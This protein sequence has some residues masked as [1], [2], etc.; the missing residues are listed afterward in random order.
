[1]TGIDQQQALA[2]A[3]IPFAGLC[4]RFDRVSNTEAKATA[5]RL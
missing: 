5:P 4:A 2:N 1:M 3:W